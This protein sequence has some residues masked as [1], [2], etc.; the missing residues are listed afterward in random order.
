MANFIASLLFFIMALVAAFSA[1]MPS[2]FL[3]GAILF[4]ALFWIVGLI[5]PLLIRFVFFRK[6]LSRGAAFGLTI[7]LWFVD[8]FIL[9]ML[10]G[11][12]MTSGHGADLWLV[13]LTFCTYNILRTKG[14]EDA[15]I[16]VPAQT[17]K[18]V[19]SGAFDPVACDKDEG[20]VSIKEN[21]TAMN[22]DAFYDVVAKELETDNLIPGVWT[23]A[24]A[25]VDG[26]E[27]RA[28]AIYIKRRVAQLVENSRRQ[29]EE[30]E[31]RRMS[32]GGDT[33]AVLWEEVNER[34]VRNTYANGEVTMSDK[35]TGRMWLLNAN[36][37]GKKKWSDAEAYCSD[38][39]YA[40]YTDWHLP[41][42]D[43]LKEQLSQKSDFSGV[44]GEIYW[45]ET[46][47][48]HGIG[49]AWSVD[50]DDGCVDYGHKARNDFYVWPV[51]GGQ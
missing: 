51:R 29:L 36:P 11:Q 6:S 3:A 12:N 28:K 2:E 8:A 27:N 22:A 31:R 46:P 9:A 47:Y 43:T 19:G 4:F 37:C 30:E 41:D 35:D 7:L 48:A 15:D 50:M 18:T 1:E 26:D 20:I 13:C 17:A 32:I 38:L 5:P 14:Q 25:E 33:K 21:T 49:Y 10:R 34:W 39:T 16:S 23:R 42:K 44:Q 24:F 40:G 45:S